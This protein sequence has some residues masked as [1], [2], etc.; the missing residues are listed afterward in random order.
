MSKQPMSKQ[1]EHTPSSGNVFADLGLDDADTLDI[2]SDLTIL[3][4]QLIHKRGWT[5]THAAEVLGIHQPD[6]SD[7]LRGKRL[8]HY[9]V[10]R[11]I[12]FL[13]QLNHRV[14]ITVEDC[15]NADINH[16]TAGN[17][18]GEFVSHPSHTTSEP[19]V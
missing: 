4:K 10:E 9:S 6:V 5:Q 7:L 18:V 2:K 1:I 13:N 12:H 15:A 8:E 19:S 17:I 14:T 3:I 11:L 16:T